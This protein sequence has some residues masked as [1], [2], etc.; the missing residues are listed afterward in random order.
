PLAQPSA[1]DRVAP[2]DWVRLVRTPAVEAPPM[3]PPSGAHLGRQD[4][5]SAEQPPRSPDRPA[6]PGH[7][8]HKPG[9]EQ[10]TPADPEKR[11][12]AHP[13][14]PQS[15][16][17]L[18]AGSALALSALDSA[19]D[20]LV[21]QTIAERPLPCWLG[22]AGWGMGAVLAWLAMRRNRRQ[23]AVALSQETPP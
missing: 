7:V 11:A 8:P 13:P 20:A 12:A 3:N 17:L 2:V 1:A 10:I 5:G 6:S 21:E 19:L 22:L 23:P 18:S 16:G 15:A 14:A 4:A 9:E